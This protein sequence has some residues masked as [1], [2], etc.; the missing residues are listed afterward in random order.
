M[1]LSKPDQETTEALLKG[2][3]ELRGVYPKVGGE[4]ICA[5]GLVWTPFDP[6]VRFS[7]RAEGWLVT[8]FVSSNWLE[9][10]HTPGLTIADDSLILYAKPMHMP[11]MPLPEGVEAW[12][13]KQ[14]PQSSLL[15]GSNHELTI[16]AEASVLVRWAAHLR[17]A[18][19]MISAHAKC[20]NDYRQALGLPPDGNFELGGHDD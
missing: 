2:V 18:K 16:A 8:F 1:A 11:M 15:P 10:V 7:R 12:W 9:Q 20:V 14:I 6:K 19:N 13:V 17:L 4:S 5:S 3:N